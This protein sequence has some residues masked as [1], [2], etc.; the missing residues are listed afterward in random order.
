MNWS[1][2]M[3]EEAAAKSTPRL[4]IQS[5]LEDIAL[6]WPWVDALAADYA[7]PD[8]TRY[9]IHL[10]LEEALSNV[11]RHGYGGAPGRPIAVECAPG[12]GELAFIVEDQAPPFD[13]LAVPPS[14]D[15]LSQPLPSEIPLGGQGIRLMRKFAGSLSYEPLPA[16]NRLTM[17]F[18]IL[19]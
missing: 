19:R 11:I 6:L 4:T 8:N 1:V 3:P 7:V 9:A 13:P 2:T 10:C 15:A 18:P 17:R 14:V 5:R 16:G 12:T